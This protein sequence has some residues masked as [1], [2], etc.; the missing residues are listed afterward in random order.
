M[1]YTLFTLTILLIFSCQKESISNVQLDCIE[2][3][4]DSSFIAMLG[5]EICL[6][7]G[8]S[9]II[10]NIKD[11]FCPCDAICK[12]EGELKVIVETTDLV[13]K[14]STFGFGSATYQL[15]PYL[16]E[17]SYIQAFSYDY[18]LG[19]LPDCINEFNA[20]KVT[21]EITISQ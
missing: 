11:E 8:S 15:R 1:K 6:P 9:F 19:S 13:G 17:D 18:E 2:I 3:D 10:K 7:D 20:Q 5:N 16:L 14:K 21:L 12:W 4:Y